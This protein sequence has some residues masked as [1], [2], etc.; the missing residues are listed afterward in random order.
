MNISEKLDTIAENVPK[1][2]DSGQKVG[3]DNGYEIGKQDGYNDGYAV[4]HNIGF[5]EGEQAE[6]DCFWDAFQDYGNRTNYDNGFAGTGW[7]KDTFAPKYNINIYNAYMMFRNSAIEAD[8]PALL[9][10]LGIQIKFDTTTLQYTFYGTKF[11]RIGE[12][13]IRGNAYTNS[14]FAASEELV[15]IDKVIC[16]EA[17]AFTTCFNGCNELKNI[18]FEGVIG[19]NG[20]NLQWSTKLS[21]DSFVSIINC[22]STTTSG[23]SV[24][25]SKTAVENAF[26]AEEWAALIATKS[27]WTISLV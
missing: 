23:L 24:T 14:I 4:G 27:N 16:N 9:Q 15:T 12:V 1:V 6:Y 21:H 17:S 5:A 8:L 19:K 2:Y 20:L 3:Y 7:T 18:T 13:N 22:L 26:T 11:T 25:L 10:E